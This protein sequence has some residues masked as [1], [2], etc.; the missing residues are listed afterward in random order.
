M[1]I[2]LF[3]EKLNS[4]ERV[5]SAIKDRDGYKVGLKDGYVFA[6]M[7]RNRITL[8]NQKDVLEFMED[9]VQRSQEEI[10]KIESIKNLEMSLSWKKSSLESCQERE[11][12]CLRKINYNKDQIKS[13]EKSIEY[14]KEN[15]SKSEESLK[16][17][18]KSNLEYREQIE[19][20][21]KEIELKKSELK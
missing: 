6:E 7:N 3:L 2:E 19:N 9:I 17:Y 13:Y 11:K 20:M 12:E 15:I 4:D 21:E 14:C 5:G 8:S 16:F 1:K 18:K 10:K